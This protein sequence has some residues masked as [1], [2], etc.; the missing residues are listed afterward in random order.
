M[1]FNESPRQ[2]TLLISV[3]GKNNDFLNGVIKPSNISGKSLP[4]HG[5][6]CN[7]TVIYSYFH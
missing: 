7:A 1:E 5:T 3:P 2:C 4:I 6:M